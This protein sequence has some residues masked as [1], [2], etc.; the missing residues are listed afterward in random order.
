MNSFISSIGKGLLYTKSY[1]DKYQPQLYT[2]NLS[3]NDNISLIL[4]VLLFHHS[5]L[6]TRQKIFDSQ[7]MG[8]NGF[9]IYLKTD[10]R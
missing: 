7:G 4:V 8:S 5:A 1:Y 9:Y 10:I 6:Q 2:M 3:Q